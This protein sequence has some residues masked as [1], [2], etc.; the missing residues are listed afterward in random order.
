MSY[1]ETRVLKWH[2]MLP[3]PSI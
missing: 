3:S 2:W 1:Y